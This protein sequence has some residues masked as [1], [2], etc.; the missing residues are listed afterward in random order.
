MVKAETKSQIVEKMLQEHGLLLLSDS[1]LPSL[2]SLV[3]GAPI[4]GSWWG[5]P[6]GRQIYALADQLGDSAEVISTKL[7]SG[8]V[9]F[10]HKKLWP[11]VARIGCAGEKWQTE[12]LS[13]AATDLLKLVRAQQVLATD[14][15][16]KTQALSKPGKA[17]DELE[18]R[19][20]VYTEE[21]HSD[22]GAHHKRIQTW[23]TWSK[24]RNIDVAPIELQQAKEDLTKILELL[25]FKFHASATLPWQ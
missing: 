5:H 15:L 9:T 18:K 16:P 13:G 6:M 2:V 8:K 19:L 1:R 10:V 24:S 25:N 23:E 17:C 12:R 4:Q 22:S 11:Q 21:F 20:L 7:I 14:S 3:V